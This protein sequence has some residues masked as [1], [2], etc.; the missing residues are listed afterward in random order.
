ML[1]PS[2]R[3]IA[4]KLLLMLFGLFIAFLLLEGGI[5]ILLLFRQQS[6][7]SPIYVEFNPD[8]GWLHIPNASGWDAEPAI[9]KDGQPVPSTR[10]FDVNINSFGF[11]DEQWKVR[12]KQGVQRIAFLGDSYVFGAGLAEH[13]RFS[14]LLE[15]ETCQ[16]LNFGV[17]GYS[18]DQE[19]LLYRSH[20]K[21]FKP[22]L[23][24]L[25]LF[26]GND[27]EDNAVPF[28][29]N[30]TKSKPYFV[31]DGNQLEL[32][33]FPVNENQQEQA[34]ERQAYFLLE[35]KRWLNQNLYSYTFIVGLLRSVPFTNSLLV[36][37][38]KTQDFA[39]ALELTAAIV[40]QLRDEARQQNAELLVLII[41]SPNQLSKGDDKRNP[42]VPYLSEKLDQAGVSYIDLL[43]E[44]KKLPNEN[45]YFA[46][47]EHLDNHGNEKVAEL[48]Q[49]HELFP[50]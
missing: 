3:K 34:D 37:A 17:S 28:P 12:G 22:D 41:P 10:L 6:P 19:L 40:E 7:A 5:R 39:P 50:C 2:K 31:L 20:V 9:L 32:K 49:Q 26:I 23:V 4:S 16:A 21:Q 47:D 48:L 18:T 13:K 43:E 33:N 44:F 1:L 14:E 46:L 35:A 15:S 8:I 25:S 30:T 29:A 24:V 42:W 38:E 27:V 45:F 11:R 36:S